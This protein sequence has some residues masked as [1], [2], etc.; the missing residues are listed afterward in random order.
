MAKEVE[1]TVKYCTAKEV[2]V[3][4]QTHG[5]NGETV[6]PFGTSPEWHIG[7]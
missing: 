6:A 1:C 5:G 7:S 4:L 3:C 2:G